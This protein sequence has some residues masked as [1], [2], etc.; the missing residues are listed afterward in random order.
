[1]EK[2]HEF[3]Q[4]GYVSSTN[5]SKKFDYKFNQKLTNL[6]ENELIIEAKELLIK[7]IERNIK[8][9][10]QLLIPISGGLDSRLILSAV[11]EC[12]NLTEVNTLT[13]GT[14]GSL[15]YEIGNYIANK[16][17][18]KHTKINLMK[19]TFTLEDLYKFAQNVDTPTVLF[20]NIP[21]SKINQNKYDLLLS[22]FL[23]D[24]ASGKRF[25]FADI[26]KENDIVKEEYF[27]SMFQ[28]HNF[29]VDNKKLLNKLMHLP[30]DSNFDNLT[31]KEIVYIKEHNLKMNVNQ[32]YSAFNNIDV[33]TPFYNT[34]FMNFLI[35]L[36]HKY[37]L[38]QNLYKKLIFENMDE[39]LANIPVKNFYGSKYT[40]SGIKK[41]IIRSKNSLIHKMS[42]KFK[43][44]NSPYVNYVDFRKKVILDLNFKKMI[45]DLLLSLKNRKLILYENDINEAIYSIENNKI[46]NPYNSLLLSSLEIYIRLG[47]IN[48][49][50]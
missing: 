36:P 26:E 17:G 37:K 45:L 18:T 12:R 44:T 24:V 41:Q 46:D 19:H 50:E 30:L 6:T 10:D 3:L 27:K 40:T 5:D 2:Y 32:V 39:K 47:K 25:N 43:N 31:Y 34:E 13:Y 35:S 23:G 8:N 33:F 15:D 4:L 20:H 42:H 22:G 49:N 7:E 38:N 29:N 16:I 48:I 1:M 28:R 9:K 11:S 21:S 14:N